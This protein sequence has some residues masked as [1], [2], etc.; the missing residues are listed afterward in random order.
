[1]LEELIEKLAKFERECSAL[2]EEK[3]SWPW[4]I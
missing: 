1:M 4:R 2:R 3:R